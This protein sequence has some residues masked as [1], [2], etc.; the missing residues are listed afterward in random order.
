[1]SCIVVYTHVIK[2]GMLPYVCHYI[3]EMEVV[4]VEEDEMVFVLVEVM[5]EGEE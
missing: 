1:M 2:I 5:E 4:Q 3:T